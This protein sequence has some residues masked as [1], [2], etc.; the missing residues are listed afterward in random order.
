[1][2]EY[3]TAEKIDRIIQ[4]TNQTP[5]TAASLLN[6]TSD[7]LD[8]RSDLISLSRLLPILY[9]VR[10]DRGKVVSNWASQNTPEAGV[11]SFG[12]HMMFW[13]RPEQFNR[14]LLEF[15]DGCKPCSLSGLRQRD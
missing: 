8:F 15:L 10:E 14:A 9:I 11:V 7:F 12:G 1:M 6:A 3:R 5:D 2:L 13:E 4:I